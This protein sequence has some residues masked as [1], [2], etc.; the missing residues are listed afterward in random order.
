VLVDERRFAEA[1]KLDLDVLER[2]RRVLGP[3][4]PINAA[5]LYNLGCCAALAGDRRK[6]LRYLREAVAHGMSG[7]VARTMAKDS[8]L[9]SLRGDPEFEALLADAQGRPNR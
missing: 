2:E 3:D 8:D 6:A 1:E 5:V 9:Q 7:E 4:H